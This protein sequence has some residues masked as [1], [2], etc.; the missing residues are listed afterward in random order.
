M[1]SIA[2][3]KK[4]DK[5]CVRECK[6]DCTEACRIDDCCQRRAVVYG[7][8]GTHGGCFDGHRQPRAYVEPGCGTQ[9]LITPYRDGCTPYVHRPPRRVLVQPPPY[10]VEVPPSPPRRRRVC[11]DVVLY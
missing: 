4:V 9:P 6:K 7:P 11:T 10:Y 5:K 3:K 2:S 1:G 8:N